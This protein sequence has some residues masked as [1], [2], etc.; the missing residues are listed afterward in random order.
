MVNRSLL[1]HFLLEAKFGDDFQPRRYTTKTGRSYDLHMN[2]PSYKR[3]YV[4]CQLDN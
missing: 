2:A 1:I 3:V 4:V